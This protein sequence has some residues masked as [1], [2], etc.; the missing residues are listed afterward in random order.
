MK[1]NIALLLLT[2][3]VFAS[4][5][6]STSATPSSYVPT[7][8]N[9]MIFT[10]GGV[11]DTLQATAD[12]TTVNGVKGIGIVG[13]NAKTGVGFNIAIATISSTGNYDVGSVSL[14]PAGYVILTY[15]KD[16]SGTILTYTSPTQPTLTS[17]SVGSLDITAISSASVQATFNGTLTLQNG[18]ST[19]SITNGGVNANFIP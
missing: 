9:T 5:K 1:I 7:T 17:T 14:S 6:M 3:T 16:S 2:V 15:T 8:T 19:V 12:D 13:V 11:T 10:V 18:T 4:C